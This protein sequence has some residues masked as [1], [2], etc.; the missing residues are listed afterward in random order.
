MMFI[1]YY[2][3]LNFIYEGQ[4]LAR[5]SNWYNQGTTSLQHMYRQQTSIEQYGKLIKETIYSI[6]LNGRAFVT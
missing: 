1:F 4:R 6:F 3:L 5:S 2:L